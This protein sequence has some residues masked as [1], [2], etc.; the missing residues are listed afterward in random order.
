[1]TVRS[2]LAARPSVRAGIAGSVNEMR[3]PSETVIDCPVDCVNGLVLGARVEV[4]PVETA[5]EVLG[6]VLVKVSKLFP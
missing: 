4:E 3:L 6:V 5:V 2:W 1:M